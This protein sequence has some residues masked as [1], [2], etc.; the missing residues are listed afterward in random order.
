MSARTSFD[1][2]SLDLAEYFLSNEQATDADKRA[3]AGEIQQAVEDWFAYRETLA[4][5]TEKFHERL[6]IVC[7]DADTT[8]FMIMRWGQ[9]NPRVSGSNAPTGENIQYGGRRQS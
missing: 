2:K 4:E 6:H 7:G 9:R 1:Q 5:A 8:D 3:L